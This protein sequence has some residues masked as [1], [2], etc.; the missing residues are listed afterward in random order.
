M[1]LRSV[2]IDY[3]ICLFICYLLWIFINGDID[4]SAWSKE[5]RASMIGFATIAAIISQIRHIKD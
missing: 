4:A 2:L 1:T 3:I 5:S